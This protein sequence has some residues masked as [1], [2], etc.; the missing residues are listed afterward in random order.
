MAGLYSD[1]R[2]TQIVRELLRIDALFLNVLTDSA[3]HGRRNCADD[4]AGVIPAHPSDVAHSL[5]DR[6]VM[7]AQNLR[8]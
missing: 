7:I 2:G 5:G 6:I 3:E 8:K 1:Y 4:F